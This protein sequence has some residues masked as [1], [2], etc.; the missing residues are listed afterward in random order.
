M[1]GSRAH[2]QE[3]NSTRTRRFQLKLKSRFTEIVSV[4]VADEE[5]VFVTPKT[6]LNA[7]IWRT[8]LGILPFVHPIKSVTT[9]DVRCWIGFPVG[10]SVSSMA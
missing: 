10:L 8:L 6:K 1:G 7:A 4:Y 9:S 3:A 5:G 2:V